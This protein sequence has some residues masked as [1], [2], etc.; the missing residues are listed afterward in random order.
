M[1]LA[2]FVCVCVSVFLSEKNGCYAL[3][4]K[5]SHKIMEKEGDKAKEWRKEDE[6]SVE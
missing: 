6:K 3:G 5:L 4:D 2:I 1:S